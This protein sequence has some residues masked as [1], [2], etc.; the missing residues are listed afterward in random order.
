MSRLLNRI[1]VLS[2]RLKPHRKS[3]TLIPVPIQSIF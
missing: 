2:N 3:L 1:N